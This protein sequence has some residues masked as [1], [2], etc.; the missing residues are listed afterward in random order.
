L[1]IL[2]LSQEKIKLKNLKIQR[3]FKYEKGEQG[4]KEVEKLKLKVEVVK[5]GCSNLR[6][7]MAQFFHSR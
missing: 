5:N 3:Y 7:Q 6:F 1:T 4:F 2:R